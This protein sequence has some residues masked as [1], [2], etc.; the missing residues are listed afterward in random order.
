MPYDY[1]TDYAPQQQQSLYGQQRAV[2]AYAQQGL[3]M[4]QPRQPFSN[5]ASGYEDLGTTPNSKRRIRIG[6]KTYVEE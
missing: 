1:G 5:A 6:G 3:A 4:L 2:P